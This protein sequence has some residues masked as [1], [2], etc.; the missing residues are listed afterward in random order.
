MIQLLPYKGR[1]CD[2]SVLDMV[3]EREERQHLEASKKQKK[4]NYVSGKNMANSLKIWQNWQKGRV[5]YI[6]QPYSI[7]KFLGQISR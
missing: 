4:Y 6:W 5:P 1:P 7:N 3:L 2:E